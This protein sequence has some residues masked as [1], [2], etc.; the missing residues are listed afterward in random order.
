M[1]E[2]NPQLTGRERKPAH[3]PRGPEKVKLQLYVLPVTERRIRQSS[4]QLGAS[5]GE[6]IDEIV[7]SRR[8]PPADL[9]PDVGPSN[10]N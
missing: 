6:F 8:D 7:N 1:Q 3:R 2:A 10:R 9:G 4:F 5:M